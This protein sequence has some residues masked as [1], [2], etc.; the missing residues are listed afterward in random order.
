MAYYWQF[1]SGATSGDWSG[2]YYSFTSSSATVT[3]DNTWTIS[4][5]TELSPHQEL[6]E[7]QRQT[8][9]QQE[10]ERRRREVLVERERAQAIRAAE[11]LLRDHLGDARLQEFKTTGQV[12]V[13]SPGRPGRR[14]I[15]DARNRIKVFEGERLV[16]ELCVHLICEHAED[17]GGGLPEADVVLGKIWL[18]LNDEERLLATANHNPVR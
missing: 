15:V 9:R 5:L 16:D 1:C 14:Y 18:L 3:W 11:D 4:P 7:E 6:T 12:V 2:N 8:Q 10:D 13:D 17:T